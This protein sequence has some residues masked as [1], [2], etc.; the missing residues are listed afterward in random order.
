MLKIASV[1]IVAV[2][3][4]S[5]QKQKKKKY[6]KVKTQQSNIVLTNAYKLH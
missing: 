6:V 1:Y 4:F 3:W 2:C 5:Q